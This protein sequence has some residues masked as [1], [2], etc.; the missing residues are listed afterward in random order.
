MWSTI[1]LPLPLLILKLSTNHLLLK[2]S[3]LIRHITNL[4]LYN[5]PLPPILV[6][7]SNKRLRL[8]TTRRLPLPRPDITTKRLAEAHRLQTHP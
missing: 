3:L 6:P 1:I 7:T 8:L 4:S 2:A 5:N